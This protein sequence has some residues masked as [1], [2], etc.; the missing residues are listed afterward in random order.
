MS[1]LLSSNQKQAK[2]YNNL[3]KEQNPNLHDI[4]NILM[5]L[6]NNSSLETQKNIFEEIKKK[7]KEKL[8]IHCIQLLLEI[9]TKFTPQ[10]AIKILK[11]AL[12]QCEKVIEDFPEIK[13]MEIVKLNILVFLANENY[14][15]LYY[16]EAIKY[17][18]MAINGVVGKSL[19]P[20]EQIAIFSAYSTIIKSFCATKS[21]DAALIY[22][23]KALEIDYD[24]ESMEEPV[25]VHLSAIYS[26]GI[27]IFI[28]QKNPDEAMKYI[29]E[30]I[31]I[32]DKIDFPSRKLDFYQ[33]I[34]GLN[35][36]KNLDIAEEYLLKSE[37]LIE[38]MLENYE[39]T[40]QINEL[41]LNHFQFSLHIFKF[42]DEKIR[43]TYDDL[44]QFVNETG[45]KMNDD[46]KQDLVKNYSNLLLNENDHETF[47]EIFKNDKEE[48]Y[49]K[50][51]VVCLFDRLH[52]FQEDEEMNEFPKDE[53]K[54]VLKIF[55][56][57]TMERITS[58]CS[59]L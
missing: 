45:L 8:D 10:Y 14:V 46:Y 19:I 40:N 57:L 34:I 15:S 49:R 13:E 3:I 48:V 53:M 44:F 50:A 18:E 20:E 25:L 37:K 21:F 9:S 24:L 35:L 5:K 43:L 27:K 55:K 16:E 33:G 4:S 41:I 12:S 7:K 54:L 6:Q 17:S 28:Q 36:T 52:K 47:F 56:F 58:K 2:I 23:R 29:E 1:S 31:K 26:D 42:D 38:E 11:I 32:I 51:M 22:F 59:I 39:Q 30:G